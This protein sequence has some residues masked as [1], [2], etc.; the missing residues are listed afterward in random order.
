M[1]HEFAL[2]FLMASFLVGCGDDSEPEQPAAGSSASATL[3]STAGNTATGTASFT[4]S[5]SQIKLSVSIAGVPPG[6]VHGFHIHDGNAC[7]TDG[8]AAGAHWDPTLSGMHGEWMMG[9]YHLG[10]IGNITADASGNGRAEVTANVWSI[11]TGEDNDVVGH[12]VVLHA[13]PDDLSGQPAGNAGA[14][15]A[16]GVIQLSP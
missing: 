10:D 16:C 11:G 13:D 2:G 1:R 15:I 12:A 7:G 3:A 9:A 6:S 5:G 14:R 4:P 8:M